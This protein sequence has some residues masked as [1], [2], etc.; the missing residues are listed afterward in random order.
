MTSERPRRAWI[1][2]V[3]LGCGFILLAYLLTHFSNHALGLVSLG[4]MEAG[5]IW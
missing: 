2:P 4:A 1:R 5:R 3:R